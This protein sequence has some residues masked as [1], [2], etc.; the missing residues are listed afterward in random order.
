MNPADLYPREVLDELSEAISLGPVI[1]AGPPGSAREAVALAALQNLGRPA[2][3]VIDPARA[4][5]LAALDT[6]VARGLLSIVTGNPEPDLDA[7]VSPT[8]LLA[9]QRH[10]D[11]EAPTVLAAARNEAVAGLDTLLGLV[12]STMAVVVRDAAQLKRRWAHDALWAIRGRAADQDA[13]RLV[14]LARSHHRLTDR[15]DAL[16]GAATTHR[17]RPPSTTQVVAALGLEGP[18]PAWMTASRRLPA[19]IAAAHR[20]GAG[21]LQAGWDVLV[22]AASQRVDVFE[23]L[24][25]NVH[26]LGPR[27][28]TAVATG[29]P[30]YG[31]VPG[32]ATALISNALAA[33]READLI[34]Q[35]AARRWEIADPALAVALSSSVRP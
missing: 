21:D 14:L 30:P 10:A 4:G 2:P 9:L 31:S 17:L 25:I 35:P 12:D 28:L 15:D 3:L 23:R 34:T 18:A 7:G 13:P 24:A 19:V 32:A 27:L 29:R 11:S 26:Q 8:M 22:S 5:T 16:F 6:D 33:L 20:L 1:L